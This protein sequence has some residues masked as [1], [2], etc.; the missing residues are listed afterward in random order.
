M[1]SGWLPVFRHQGLITLRQAGQAEQ[2]RGLACAQVP[3]KAGCQGREAI[4][5]HVNNVHL[6]GQGGV[7]VWGGGGVGVSHR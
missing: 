2:H 4:R 5:Q 7:C 1:S 6:V 3:G